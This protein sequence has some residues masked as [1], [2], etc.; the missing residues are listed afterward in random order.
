MPEICEAEGKRNVNEIF[1][2][3]RTQHWHQLSL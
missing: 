2:V 1:F 3:A